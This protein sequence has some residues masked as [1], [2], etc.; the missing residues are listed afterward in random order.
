[1]VRAGQVKSERSKTESCL[2]RV[3]RG[4]R[5]GKVE[6]QLGCDLTTTACLESVVVLAKAHDTH[7]ATLPR[8]ACLFPRTLRH[9][10]GN[11]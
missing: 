2:P 1:M 7:V 4:F 3:V 6:A 10:S 5:C 11:V 8:N 9:I